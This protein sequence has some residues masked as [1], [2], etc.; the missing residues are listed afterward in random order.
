M[1]VADMLVVAVAIGLGVEVFVSRK[2]PNRPAFVWAAAIGTVGM[3]ISAVVDPETRYFA[4]VMVLVGCSQLYRAYQ[5]S[6]AQPR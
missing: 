5:A 6:R 2:S 4:L 3:A 1:T